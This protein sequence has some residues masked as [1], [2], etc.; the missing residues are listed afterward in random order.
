MERSR[1]TSSHVHVGTPLPGAVYDEPGNLLLNK[2]YTIK[3]QEQ[4]DALLGRG[5]YVDIE[6]FNNIFRPASSAAAP[7]ERKFDPFA[8]RDA[9]KIRLNRSLRGLLSAS[10]PLS[11]LTELAADITDYAATDPDA[12]VAGALI[13][14]DAD[15]Y[16]VAHSLDCGI[17]VSLAAS[18]LDW[19]PARRSSV[20]CAA[21]T[22]NLGMLDAQVKLYRQAT[23][24]ND[25]QRESV[26]AHPTHSAEHL[27]KVGVT[28]REWLEAIEQHHEHP[29]KTGY[30]KGI[31]NPSDASQLIR[32]ADLFGARI[33]ARADRKAAPAP[34]VI[35]TLFADEAK[36]PHANLANALV[37]S[38][39]IVPPGSFVVLANHEVGVV[40]RHGEHVSTPSVAVV[41]HSSGTPNM[42]PVRRET[43]RKEFAITSLLTGDK[44]HCGYDLGRLWITNR[45]KA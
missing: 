43:N 30:P 21:L 9:L 12:A 25:S 31:A 22:V 38:V 10:E 16:P 20:V 1:L 8:I 2:G 33:R 40:F 45:H 4:L 41:T 32:M 6:A 26:H 35:R 24:L 39:G 34:Q 18:H 5:M 27:S 7:P 42:Q 29:G 23:P 14:H 15:S 17:F 11:S 37:K 19:P 28:D 36:G 3:D 44:V 13:D